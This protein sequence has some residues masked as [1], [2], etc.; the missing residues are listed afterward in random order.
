VHA[1]RPALSRSVGALQASSPRS[2]TSQCHFAVPLRGATSRCPFAVRADVGVGFGV[3]PSPAASIPLPMQPAIQKFSVLAVLV[4]LAASGAF[5]F[6]SRPSAPRWNVVLLTLDTTRADFLGT[7]G[8][9]GNPTPVLDALAREGTRFDCAIAT[10]S[11]TPVSHAS[12]LTGLH[13]REHGVR[14]LLGMCGY[15]LQPETPTLA[16]VLKG[17]GYATAAVHSAFPVSAY[18]GFHHGFDVFESFEGA[19]GRSQ[20]GTMSWPLTELQR[21]SDDTTSIVVEELA[22]LDD[23]FFLWVHYWDPHDPVLVPP[24]DRMQGVPRGPQGELIA[25]REL[26]GAEVSYLDEQIGRLFDALRASGEWER[27]LVVVVADHG[28]GLGDHG[29][30]FHR[31]L[32]QEQIR[33]PL[34]VRLPGVATAPSVAGTVSTIDIAPTVLDYLGVEPPRAL[35]G[36]TLRPLLEGRPDPPRSAFADQV[37]GYDLNAAMLKSRPLDGFLYA[38]VDGG[39]KL[40]WRPLHPEASELYHLDADPGELDNRLADSPDQVLRLQK[41]LARHGAWVTSPCHDASKAGV[42]Q[43]EARAILE[44]LGYAGGDE[45]VEAR[46]GF[47][48]PGEPGRVVTDPVELDC[49]DGVLL[50]PAPSR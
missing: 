22:A 31:I 35:S 42:D 5:W 33:V 39:W 15:A 43:A 50:V 29:W 44:K 14:V 27:T 28:E 10:A 23:P 47:A 38:V 37:N 11:V 34:L 18:F 48:C 36:R 4:V 17:A 40:V 12:I 25:S 19:V 1:R 32:Y 45:A 46:W 16:T 2:A 21:R 8:R 13:N 7:Y 20:A 49:P 41:L 26:Y 24:A 30:A 6:A 3:G 9:A